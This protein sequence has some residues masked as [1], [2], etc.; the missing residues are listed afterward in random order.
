ME[1]E[2]KLSEFEGPLDLLLHLIKIQQIDIYDIPIAQITDQYLTFL[3][4]TQA[5]TLD[6]AGDYLVMAANLMAIKSR[7]LLPRP[8]S[9]QLDQPDEAEQDPREVLVAQLLAYQT[10]QEVGHYLQS[11][12]RD[13]SQYF[14]KEESSPQETITTPLPP[15]LVTVNEMAAAL[16]ELLQQ[17]QKEAHFSQQTISRETFSL[18][19][20]IIQIEAQLQQAAGQRVT[21]MSLLT[22]QFDREQ[23]VVFF[24]ACLELMKNKVIC[25]HQST[26]SQE[27]QLSEE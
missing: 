24:L 13:R 15:D 22:G 27:I 19:E 9:A 4:E 23:V 17:R 2:I 5:L 10:Y 3:H 21:F 8:K 12:E 20:A 7:M 14:V 16:S 18:D 6:V 11:Q 25:C 1:L 26:F